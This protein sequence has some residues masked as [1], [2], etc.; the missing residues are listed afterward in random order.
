LRWE[1][2]FQGQPFSG[3]PITNSVQATGTG[4]AWTVLPLTGIEIKELIYKL[5]GQLR[6]KWRVREEYDLAKLIDGQRF[7]RWFHGYANGVGDIG[8]LPVE[9][10]AFSGRAEGPENVLDWTTATESNSAAFEVQRS[11]D[12]VTFTTIGSLPAAGQSIVLNAYTFRDGEPPSGT[13]YYRL[14]MLD[15]DGTGELSPTIAI[16]R[17]LITA[18]FPNPA[19]DEVLIALNGADGASAVLIIDDLGRMLL[20]RDL[21]GERPT[22]L[23][24]VPLAGM[25]QGHY[26]LQLVNAEGQV[27]DRVSFVKR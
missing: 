23:L 16:E 3:A 15:I 8:V 17:G 6:Y 22:A 10:V 24:T 18:L 2:V 1:V 9:L 12:A 11:G 5:P 4:A 25:A 7:G 21:R 20:H 27:L 26:T 19:D 14:N 13:S